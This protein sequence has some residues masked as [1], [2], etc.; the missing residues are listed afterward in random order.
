MYSLYTTV[1]MSLAVLVKYHSLYLCVTEH[2]FGLVS[3][4]CDSELVTVCFVLSLSTKAT[5]RDSIYC[6][7]CK[8]QWG[9][10]EKELECAENI[11]SNKL[12]RHKTDRKKE[13]LPQSDNHTFGKYLNGLMIYRNTHS[14]FL[15]NLMMFVIEEF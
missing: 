8:F 7:A 15:E 10:N 13:K 6:A 4:Y 9:I 14:N 12:R 2:H 3:V 1:N 11:H 5:D